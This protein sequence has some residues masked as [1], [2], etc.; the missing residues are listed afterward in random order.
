M[1]EELKQWIKTDFAK[2]IAN[3]VKRNYITTVSW[4]IEIQSK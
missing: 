3:W 4:T 2:E 1:K